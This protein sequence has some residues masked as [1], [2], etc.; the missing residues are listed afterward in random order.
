MVEGNRL[1]EI[2]GLFGNKKSS[3][4]FV[5]SDDGAGHQPASSNGAV[6]L[7]A[8]KRALGLTDGQTLMENGIWLVRS[9]DCRALQG[10][11]Y[12]IGTLQ[13]KGKNVGIYVGSK[14]VGTVEPRGLESAVKMLKRQGGRRVS[15]VISQT[16]A[17]S[18][19]VYV[20]MV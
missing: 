10:D 14:A 18:W 20:N 11:D 15:C 17:G 19:N 13:P 7:D 12:W 1:G 3:I 2:M 6:T 9:Q 5:P 4:T 16:G 8:A